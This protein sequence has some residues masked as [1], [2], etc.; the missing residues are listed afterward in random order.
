MTS[1]TSKSRRPMSSGL[2]RHV[3]DPHVL[4]MGGPDPEEAPK[5]RSM[6]AGG[7]PEIPLPVDASSTLFVEGVPADC[8]LREV[9]RILSIIWVSLFTILH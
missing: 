9:S 6:G 2:G 8:T 5:I 1:R 7:W 3:K 4:G